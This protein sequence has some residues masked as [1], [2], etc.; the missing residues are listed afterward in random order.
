MSARWSDRQRRA[1]RRRRGGLAR[2]S[3]GR[4][5]DLSATGQFTSIGL[6]RAVGIVSRRRNGVRAHVRLGLALAEQFRGLA[7]EPGGHVNPGSGAPRPPHRMTQSASSSSISAGSVSRWSMGKKARAHS[8]VEARDRCVWNGSERRRTMIRSYDRGDPRDAR[9]T[10]AEE[11]SGG[12]GFST[13]MQLDQTKR[14]MLDRRHKGDGSAGCLAGDA[15]RL[16][17]RYCHAQ[18]GPDCPEAWRPPEDR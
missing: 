5:R 14:V 15:G 3:F 4:S 12:L 9:P 18:Q 6:P 16:G 11:V 2:R 17:R 1:T 7:V 8:R 13:T 10:V